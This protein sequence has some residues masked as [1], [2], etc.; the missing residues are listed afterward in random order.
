MTTPLT[1]PGPA[2]RVLIV[3]DQTLIRTGFR[4]ILTARGIEVVGEAADGVEAVSSARE[5][6]PD[7]V[8]M[9]IRM[10]NMDG[11]DAT[12]RILRQ[13]PECRVLMLTT[14]DLDRYVYTA[15]SIGASGFLLKDVTPE[16]LAAAVRLVS[17][18]DALLAPSI[19]RRL[20]E[21]FATDPAHPD[22]RPPTVPADLATLT[23][24][25][26]EVLTLLGRGL[27]NTE[28]AAHLTLSEATVKSHVARIFAKLSLRDRAQAVVLAYETA[29][30]RPG[31]TDARRTPHR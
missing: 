19:T 12:R 28:L 25:E 3:D 1:D 23:P 11:L 13:A 15:L 7:V 24:R 5:L 26:L 9:D 22:G 29:L 6:R 18:G 31:D 10:P 8:L 30:V 14:F 17:T 16:H 27:S 21:R 2:P 20:V 4:L